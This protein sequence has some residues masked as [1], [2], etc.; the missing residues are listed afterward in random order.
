[1][2]K[3][4]A[5]KKE[6]QNSKIPAKSK[7]KN[8]KKAATEQQEEIP[9][10]QPDALKNDLVRQTI[11]TVMWRK[12][13]VT[14]ATLLHELKKEIGHHFDGDLEQYA[15][16]VKDDLIAWKLM[17]ESPG[18]KPVQYRLSQKLEKNEDEE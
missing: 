5:K 14:V 4:S 18:K 8:L 3:T 11:I 15:E 12:E 13:E 6:T 16:K 2:K 9:S 7:V 10:F 17:E 1:M